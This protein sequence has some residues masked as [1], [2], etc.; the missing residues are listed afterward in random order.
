VEK[1]LLVLSWIFTD[2]HEIWYLR[3]Y[4]KILRENSCFIAVWQ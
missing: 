2:F 1:R 4:S 3:I